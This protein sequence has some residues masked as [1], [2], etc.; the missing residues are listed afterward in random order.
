MELLQIVRELE[1]L[2]NQERLSYLLASLK[3]LKITYTIQDYATGANVITT[4]LKEPFIGVAS[5][6][7][8]VPNSP[9]ANDNA[10]AMA[11]CLEIAR[12]AQEDKLNNLGIQVYFFD[13]E[14]TGLKGSRAFVK[15]MG[16]RSLKALINL[17]MV[18]MGNQL[19]L[20]PLDKDYYGSV[21]HI[22]EQ[23][24]AAH[25]IAVKRFDKIVTNT[26]DHVSFREGGLDDVFTVSC[27]SD[28]D[29]EVAYHYYKAQ[30]FEVDHD[31]LKS[32]M[33]QAPL[34][35]HYHQPTDKAE[36][37]SED[38]LQ[39]ATKAIWETILAADRKA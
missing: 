24:A 8:V 28:R 21:L 15:E 31:T 38:A 14:E 22:F 27:V 25:D 39:L 29:L 10:S 37:L 13:E 23:T 1:G 5:H 17:E 12:R 26:S 34:F 19:A 33:S 32:I 7:D 16:L 11:V 2:S 18:G 6:F 9:G 35:Q 20:W 4:P 3:K 36:H 30:E